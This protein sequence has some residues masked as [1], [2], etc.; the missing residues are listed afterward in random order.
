MP[1]QSSVFR[2]LVAGPGDV[3]PERQ[4]IVA[5]IESWNR[6]H[7]DHVGLS[8]RPVTWEEARPDLSTDAQAAINRQI[9]VDR[10]AVI[11]VFGTRVGTATP[12]AISG[13]V[14]EIEEAVADSKDVMVYFS[15]GPISREGLNLEQ[16]R[17]LE[18]LRASLRPRGLL[19]S[20]TSL[21]ALKGKLDDHIARLGYDFQRQLAIESGGESR[22][23]AERPLAE[24]RQ[25][26]QAI[27]KILPG[28]NDAGPWI[29]HMSDPTRADVKYR[30]QNIGRAPARDIRARI[31]IGDSDPVEI[32][33]PRILPSLATADR[34]GFVLKMPAPFPGAPGS[35]VPEGYPDSDVITI[36]LLFSDFEHDIGE[37]STEPFC[38][39]FAR[40]QE[41]AR[42][43]SRRVACPEELDES[44]RPSRQSARIRNL[45]AADH[46][47]IE[48]LVRLAAT[49]PSV[50]QPTLLTHRMG[51]DKQLYALEPVRD[52]V[53]LG[54]GNTSSLPQALSDGRE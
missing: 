27:L 24:G 51:D 16:L 2:V 39:Q 28:E 31:V 14:E 4:A 29:F 17:Q 32:R 9:G 33:G 48:S 38:F 46:D 47:V 7:A 42:W 53:R 6:R 40:V 19:G 22:L 35:P 11:A 52:L 8:M 13:T 20:Y 21:D 15:D 26:D 1:R 41:G 37:K 50:Y 25:G 36:T 44:N 54:H 3:G 5:A 23:S 18:D 30:V 10:D 34:E 43:P 45:T 12:R 49:K